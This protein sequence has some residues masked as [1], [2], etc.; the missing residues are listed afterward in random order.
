MTKNFLFETI[1][2]V[3]AWM[4]GSIEFEDAKNMAVHEILNVHRVAI[5]INKKSQKG[6]R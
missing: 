4:N 2:D 3:C 1:V 6:N 5:K